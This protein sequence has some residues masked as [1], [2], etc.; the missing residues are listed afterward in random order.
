MDTE[1]GV[2][3][4]LGGVRDPVFG[5]VIMFGLGGI[6]VEVLRDVAFRICPIDVVDADE[7]IREIRGYEVLAGARGGVSVDLAAIRDALLKLSQLLID[8]PRIVEIDLNPVKAKAQ[9][10]AVL[11]AR[12]LAR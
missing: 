9:G 2:E 8:H 5:P 4:I 3:V 7:M 10:L 6:F 1:D 12:N 11:D